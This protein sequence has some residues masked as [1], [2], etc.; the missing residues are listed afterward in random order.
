MLDKLRIKQLYH[1][2]GGIAQSEYRRLLEHKENLIAYDSDPFRYD[3]RMKLYRE[4]DRLPNGGVVWDGGCGT[5]KAI[6]NL[7]HSRKYHHLSFLGIDYL[8]SY[9][10]SGD[11]PIEKPQLPILAGLIEDLNG[12]VRDAAKS[13]HRFPPNLIILD[14]C[15]YQALGRKTL[16]LVLKGAYDVLAPGGIVLVYDERGMEDPEAETPLYER[17]VQTCNARK[18]PFQIDIPRGDGTYCDHYMRMTK[19]KK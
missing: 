18:I 7:Q 15:L 16:D 2:Y 8:A 1:V 10:F 11:L 5:G 14:N 3:Q 13:V 19:E 12:G 6:S 17:I 9:L 4:L